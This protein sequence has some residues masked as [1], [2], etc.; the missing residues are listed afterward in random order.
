MTPSPAQY[1]IMFMMYAGWAKL[2]Y[3]RWQPSP[4][5]PYRFQRRKWYGWNE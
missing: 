5:D 2:F 4:I 1:L 3:D